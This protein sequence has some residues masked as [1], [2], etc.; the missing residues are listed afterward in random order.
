[1]EIQGYNMPDDLRYQENH[2]WIKVQGDV[3]VMGMDDFAQQMAG[4][5]VDVQL[6]FV[7]KKSNI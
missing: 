7:G 6:P 2:Y 4:E 1:M 3:L 5:I